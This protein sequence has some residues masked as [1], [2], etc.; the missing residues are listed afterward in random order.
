MR[1]LLVAV[2]LAIVQAHSPIPRQTA[3]NQTGASTQSEKQAN[4]NKNKSSQPLSPSNAVTSQENKGSVQS[5]P[6][7]NTDETIAVA[8]LSPVSVK[9][10]WLDYAGTVSTLL[11]TLATLAIAVYAAIQARAAKQSAINEER[12]VRLTER[13]DVLV[14]GVSIVRPENNP[15]FADGRVKLKFRNFGR[16][17]A[18]NVKASISISVPDAV[19]ISPAPLPLMVLAAGGSVTVPFDYFE[20]WLTKE[21]MQTIID[22]RAQLR[23]DATITYTDVFGFPH[24]TECGGV[25][26]PSDRVFCLEYNRAT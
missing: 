16:T 3:N 24:T 25:W 8:K 1:T 13:A 5:Q 10:D 15:F 18:N 2:L 22:G 19:P 11:L 7:T 6:K 23:F 4:A 17:R 26:I 9:R 21:T 20:K 14:E 12:A